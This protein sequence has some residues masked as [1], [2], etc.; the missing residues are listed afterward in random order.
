MG[1]EGPAWSWLSQTSWWGYRGHTDPPRHCT[2]L[3]HLHIHH[4]FSEFWHSFYNHKRALANWYS[5]TLNCITIT[6]T[7]F[8]KTQRVPLPPLNHSTNSLHTTIDHQHAQCCIQQEVDKVSMKTTWAFM[9]LG[10]VYH[11]YVNQTCN[12][13]RKYNNV[14]GERWQ[15]RTHTHSEHG[16]SSVRSDR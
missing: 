5:F 13:M 4:T 1:W 10:A 3:A 14:R 7:V 11:R 9:L 6:H 12:T 16:S 2:A 15:R 8:S